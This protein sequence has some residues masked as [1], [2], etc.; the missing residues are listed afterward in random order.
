M[1]QN[2]HIS[3]SASLSLQCIFVSQILLDKRNLISFNCINCILKPREVK[4]FAKVTVLL[5][6]NDKNQ[7]RKEGRKEGRK[8][9]WKKRRKGEWKGGR[10]GGEK[11]KYTARLLAL[12][13]ENS[14]HYLCR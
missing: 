13:S 3:K 5:V 7:A 1:S 2:K 9:G 10:E 6:A 4:A 8:K 12:V 14:R 11:G